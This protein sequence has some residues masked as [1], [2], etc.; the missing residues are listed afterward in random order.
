MKFLANITV[1][2]VLKF[3]TIATLCV[4]TILIVAKLFI[5]PD[6]FEKLKELVMSLIVGFVGLVNRWSASETKPTNE[7]TDTVVSAEVKK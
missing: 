6:Y 1:N 7:S 4:V 2:D 5:N 3:I